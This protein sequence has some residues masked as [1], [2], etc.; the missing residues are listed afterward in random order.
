MVIFPINPLQPSVAFLYPSE[1]IK[2]P[3][4]FLFSG[5]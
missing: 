2:K 3:K 5:V 4:E 1:N